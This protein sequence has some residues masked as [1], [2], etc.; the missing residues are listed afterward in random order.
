LVDKNRGADKIYRLIIFDVEGV[1]IPK[2][3]YLLFE[4][5]R[6]IGY[7]STLKLIV[8]G[9][10]YEAW[11]L[12]LESALKRIFILFQGLAVDD[13]FQLYK[14]V[15]LIPS[16]EEVFK[17]LKQ[18]GYRTALISSGLPTLFVEHLAARLGAD[19][20]FGL[21]LETT[22]NRFTGKISGDVIKHNGKALVLKKIIERERLSPQDCVVVADD[23]NNLSLFPLCAVRIGYN[24][25]FLVSA[26]CDFVVKGALSESLPYLT[27]ET[28]KTCNLGLSRSDFIRE[29]IHIGG[30]FVPFVCILLDS[31]LVS[32]LIFIV[33]LLYIASEL[34]R[35]RGTNIPVFS[36][37][38]WRAAIKPEFYE[39]IT[40][41]IIY[42]I[43]IMV[44]LILFPSPIN[45]ASIAILALGDGFATLFGK[46]FGR[47]T[48]PFNKGKQVEGSFFGFLFAFMG[49]LAFVNPTQ[50]LIASAIGMLVESLPTPVSDNLTVPIVSGLVLTV[51]S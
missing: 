31:Y 13:L 24:P 25:D 29:A 22:D 41:P 33:T 37:L 19:Y 12:P 14:Q 4:A 28:T 16:V 3:R 7:W 27:G 9:L 49:A 48:F 15:P 50:A 42:A 1:L 47:T 17:K 38:T 11:M 10:L 35:L 51:I 34:V 8:I 21:Q 2:R 6:R 23:R 20:A 32:S 30:V 43:A 44:S 46:K 45:Y 26:K 40:A 18:T 39:F 36:T 5:A